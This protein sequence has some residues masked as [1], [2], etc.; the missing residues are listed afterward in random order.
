MSNQ[1]FVF[2]EYTVLDAAINY[3]FGRCNVQFNAYNLTDK[4]YFTGSRSG[5]T[6]AGLGDPFNFRVG[7]SYQIR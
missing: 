5:T 6:T 3:Q 4:R 1:N 7:M 2:P